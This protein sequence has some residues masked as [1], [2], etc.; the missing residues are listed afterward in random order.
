[1]SLQQQALFIAP[2]D[3]E[4]RGV[5]AMEN[6]NKGEI[7]EICPVIILS[8]KDKKIIHKTLL[9]DYYF[10][11]GKKQKQAAIV[12]GYGSIY[13]HSYRPNAVYLRNHKAKTMDIICRKAIKA[14]D[15]ITINYNGDPKDK[16]AVWFDQ[17]N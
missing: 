3:I 10:L 15:E 9:H 5:F 4:G 17:S 11:W 12:L 1:M 8:K 13:N 14:G 2:S 7:I 16:T 6:I